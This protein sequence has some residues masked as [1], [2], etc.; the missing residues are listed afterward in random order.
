MQGAATLSINGSAMDSCSLSP[1]PLIYSHFS[2]LNSTFVRNIQVQLFSISVTLTNMQ[3]YGTNGSKQ[4][5]Y[6]YEQLFHL[7]I[8]TVVKIVM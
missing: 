5:H 6:Y 3:I 1:F 8:Q 7:N 2:F 4:R